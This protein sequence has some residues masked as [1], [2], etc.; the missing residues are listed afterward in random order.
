MQKYGE[1][2]VLEDRSCTEC[3]ECDQCELDPKKICDNC[4]KCIDS[5]AEFRAIEIEDIILNT[6]DIDEK[7]K[8]V[9]TFRMKKDK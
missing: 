6:E 7:P 5:D 8:T 2:C 4:C 3:G 9:K 1:P